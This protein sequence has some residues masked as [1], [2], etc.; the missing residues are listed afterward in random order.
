ML[1]VCTSSVISCMCEC[2]GK[3]KLPID[4]Q[5]EWYRYIDVYAIISLSRGLAFGF[6]I[7]NH[8]PYVCVCVFVGGREKGGYIM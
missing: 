4:K 1:S 2:A 6:F 8:N 5:M 7:A 3:G